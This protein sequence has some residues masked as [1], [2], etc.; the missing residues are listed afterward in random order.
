[1]GSSRPH[2]QGDPIMSV[3]SITPEDAARLVAGGAL[4]VDIREPAERAL[5][6]AGAHPAPLSTGAA[7][8]AARPGQ[9]VIFHCRSGV[10]TRMNAG[11]LA[12]AIARDDVYLL[13]GGIDGWRA[14]GLP[15]ESR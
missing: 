10:R 12:E 3:K 6:I 8:V 14:A 9:P 7:G 15:V 1:D 5:V 11:V 4:L 13:E 2:P